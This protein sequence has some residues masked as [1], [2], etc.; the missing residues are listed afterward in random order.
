[1][2]LVEVDAEVEAAVEVVAD[3]KINAAVWLECTKLPLSVAIPAV[4]ILFGVSS[5]IMSNL[6]R[7]L[8]L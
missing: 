2:P 6:A 3:G 4:Y 8:G 7:P 5:R 1:M